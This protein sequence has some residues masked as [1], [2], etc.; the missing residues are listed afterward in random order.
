MLPTAS[1]VAII[2]VMPSAMLKRNVDNS[3]LHALS[4]PTALLPVI[5]VLLEPPSIVKVSASAALT[6]VPLAASLVSASARAVSPALISSSN[7]RIA[8]PAASQIA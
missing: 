1:S 2:L 5:S 6:T 8:F 4:F 3:V 7:Q